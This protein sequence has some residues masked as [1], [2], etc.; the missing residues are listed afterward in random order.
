MAA[1]PTSLSEYVERVRRVLGGRAKEYRQFV[2]IVADL[3]RSVAAAG[4][5]AATERVI[6]QVERAVS[7]LDGQPELIAGL[8]LF[9][10]PQYRIDVQHDAVVVKVGRHLGRIVRD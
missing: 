4:D 5:D 2:D 3:G 9:L 10:P 7:L 8:R 6:S 1:A